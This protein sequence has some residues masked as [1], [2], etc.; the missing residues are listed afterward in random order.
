MFN[1][2]GKMVMM[3]SLVVPEAARVWIEGVAVSK[4]GIVA[5]AGPAMKNDGAAVAFIAC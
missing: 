4:M 2:E 3:T 5:V 1:N